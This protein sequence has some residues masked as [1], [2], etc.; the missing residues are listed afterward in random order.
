MLANKATIPR[1]SPTWSVSHVHVREFSDKTDV[2]MG[3]SFPPI[4]NVNVGGYVYTTSLATL[5][6]FP[7]SMLGC[8]F[9]GRLDIAKDTRGNYFIDR[10]GAMFR[11]I[12][13]FLRTSELC[14]PDSFEEFDQLNTEVDF[15]QITT[16]I[17]ALE[18][19]RQDRLK[20]MQLREDQGVIIISMDRYRN[21]LLLSGRD[22]LVK[23]VFR[24]FIS[25]SEFALTL[26]PARGYIRNYRVPWKPGGN[27][28]TKAD[29]FDLL[30]GHGFVL[31]ASTGGG[32][33]AD[34]P[35]TQFQEYVFVRT[36]KL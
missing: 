22:S 24:E 20:N 17:Q 3:D 31:E 16:M 1:P 36:K 8:M 7:D 12:L 2:D 9:S 33:D 6:R 4:V 29:A 13:N 19:Y 18:V 5:L 35:G 21:Q 10:D 14:L 28:L 30:Y 26:L 15:Y 25:P 23:E 32:S 11:Y 27:E 34:E